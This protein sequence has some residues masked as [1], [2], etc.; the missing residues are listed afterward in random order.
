MKLLNIGGNTKILKGDKLGVFKTAILHLAPAN[1][2][3]HEVCRG[4]SKGCA[5]ACLNTSGRGNMNNVQI[6]RINK[7]KF[8]FEQPLEAKNLLYKELVSFMNS[9]KKNDLKPAA[10]LNGTS[11]LDWNIICPDIFNLDIQYYDYTKV[12]SKMRQFL[13]G[14]LPKNYHLTFSRSESN[15][16]KVEEIIKLGGNVAVV[17]NKRPRKYL[18]TIV[19]DGDK[20]DLRFLDPKNRI[21]G[22]TPKGRGKKDLTG[23]IL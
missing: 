15:Q 8:F 22:L 20:T 23:F 3:G 21:I 19:Y 10:R 16:K 12:A 14:K 13:E 11:D 18:D 6:A 4:R 7:T 17:F 2:S 5:E 9:C 1:L